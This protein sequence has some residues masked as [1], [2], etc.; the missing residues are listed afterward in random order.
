MSEPIL[1]INSGSVLTVLTIFCFEEQ[2]KEK[3]YPLVLRG[4]WFK[5]QVILCDFLIKLL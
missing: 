3:S 5:K 4:F 1:L 2:T